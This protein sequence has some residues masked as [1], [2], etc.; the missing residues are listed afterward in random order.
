MF[1]QSL[2]LGGR[3]LRIERSRVKSSELP[4]GK[5]HGATRHRDDGALVSTHSP[6]LSSTESFSLR[7]LNAEQCYVMG[8]LPMLGAY[9]PVFPPAP[10]VCTVVLTGL[11]MDGS[12]TRLAVFKKLKN[13]GFIHSIELIGPGEWGPE[14]VE[15][16]HHHLPA[17]TGLRVLVLFD[18]PHAVE[19]VCFS[20][21][22]SPSASL[23]LSSCGD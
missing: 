7:T 20:L 9:H 17:T 10:P 1:K 12:V 2:Y 18:S 21:V 8:S 6:P 14:V 22:P 15:G 5:S 13:F 11:P 16:T 23:V 3:S 4:G 19:R